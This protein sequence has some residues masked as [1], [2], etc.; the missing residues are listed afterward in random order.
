[1]VHRNISRRTAFVFSAQR[2]STEKPASIESV[3]GYSLLSSYVRP[4]CDCDVLRL[5][6]S[7]AALGR[8]SAGS[9]TQAPYRSR[10]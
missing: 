1:M 8:V 7:T 5:I 6:C 3:V 10:L 2:I 9:Y 4:P